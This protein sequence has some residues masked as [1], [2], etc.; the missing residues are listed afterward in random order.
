MLPFRSYGLRLSHRLLTHLGGVSRFMLKALGEGLTVDMIASITALSPASLEQ[1][2]SFLSQHGFLTPAGDCSSANVL[3]DRGCRMIKIE[4]LLERDLLPVWL[5]AFTLKRNMALMLVGVGSA[6]LLETEV[7]HHDPSLETVASMPVRPR[8]YHSF[9]ELNRVRSL[10]PEQ[11]ALAQLL[12]GFCQ[13]DEGLAQEELDHWEFSLVRPEEPELRHL[14]LTFPAGGLQLSPALDESS[15]WPHVS[16]PVLELTTR[17]SCDKQLPWMVSLPS[18]ERRFVEL[19]GR[20]EVNLCQHLSSLVQQRVGNDALRLPES[21]GG[22][23]P[24]LPH[25]RLEPGVSATT[26][27]RRFQFPCSL[28]AD[29]IS[30]RLLSEHRGHVL[31]SRAHP[32]IGKAA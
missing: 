13:A 6:E 7:A 32:I 4:R 24:D 3:T 31:I 10:L 11:E 26:E 1:H 25:V 5:D 17:F 19:V 21:V 12:I 9:D 29:D 14:P 20:S 22:D 8:S 23:A 18:E 16:L 27:V 2:L 30:D 15:G 28:K